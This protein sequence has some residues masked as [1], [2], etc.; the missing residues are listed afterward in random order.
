MEEKDILGTIHNANTCT[1][2]CFRMLPGHKGTLRLE[3]QSI[4]STGL[5]FC[6][7]PIRTLQRAYWT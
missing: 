5:Q 2:E 4:H 3:S 1:M 7:P 6:I